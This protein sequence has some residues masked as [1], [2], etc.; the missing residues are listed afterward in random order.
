M[1]YNAEELLEIENNIR[2]IIFNETER[3]ISTLN[4]KNQLDDLINML[5]IQ[6]SNTDIN[7]PTGK[8]YVAAGSKVKQHDLEG[9]VKGLGFNKNRFEFHLDY[10][11]LKTTNFRHLKNNDNYR[12]I[13]IGESPHSGHG[14][15]KGSSIVANLEHTKGYP[16][17][18]RLTDDNGRL[19]L[20]KTGFK[21][22][23]ENLL[24]E[25]YIKL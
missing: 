7:Y 11:D 5:G 18:V 13:L 20:T 8:I 15:G 9:V 14:K 1:V 25:K 3:I 4:R 21:K 24:E 19:K 23:L 12:V 16:R 10:E 2:T 6:N 17:V 22:V